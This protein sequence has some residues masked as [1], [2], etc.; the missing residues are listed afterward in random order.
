MFQSGDFYQID[1]EIQRSVL[2]LPFSVGLLLSQRLFAMCRSFAQFFDDIYRSS[3]VTFH[4]TY[5]EVCIDHYLVP[6]FL[7]AH[8][9]RHDKA[10]ANLLEKQDAIG[11]RGLGSCRLT[12]CV[13]ARGHAACTAWSR[14]RESFM[15][16]WKAL[17]YGTESP[18]KDGVVLK[19][20]STYCARGTLAGRGYS[21]H[22]EAKSGQVKCK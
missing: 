13:G 9:C 20:R 8:L 21:D 2:V 7:L 12:G 11:D 1:E 15:C 17:L 6:I 3:L 4:D 14:R 10:I 16:M 22:N 19:L 18:G 5:A